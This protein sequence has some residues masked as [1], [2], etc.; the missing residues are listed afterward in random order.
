M[1][2]ADDAMHRALARR[3]AMKAARLKT[4]RTSPTS[5]P[6]LARIPD[7]SKIA[8]RP[9]EV[10]RAGGA[11]EAWLTPEGLPVKAEYGPDDRAGLDFLEGWPGLPPYLRG[12]YPTMYVE[13][14]WTIRQYAGFSTAEEF[15]RILPAQSRGGTEG[16]LRRLRS[17]DA[18]RLRFR[19]PAGGGRCRH[20][21][22]RHR[23]RSTTCARSSP[24]SRSTRL[25]CR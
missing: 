3:E 13:K 22:R 23:F 19:S 21:R 18:P 1:A 8:W 4:S 10:Q 2:R 25:A 11:R 6:P 17:A 14:P 20:G 9:P 16:P 12:P 15:E 7:F 5:P 24:A